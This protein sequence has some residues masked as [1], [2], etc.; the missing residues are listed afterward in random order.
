MTLFF[1]AVE[2]PSRHRCARVSPLQPMH[3]EG[4]PQTT[5]NGLPIE[6]KAIEGPLLQKKDGQCGTANERGGK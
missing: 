1:L 4:C 5:R 6:I 2:I 3:M